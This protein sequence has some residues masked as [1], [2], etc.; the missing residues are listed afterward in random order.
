MVAAL[1]SAL[2][3]M[4]AQEAGTQ[5][6]GGKSTDWGLGTDLSSTS[7][8]AVSAVHV[9]AT[10]Y[11]FALAHFQLNH[12]HNKGEFDKRGFVLVDIPVI[13]EE[14]KVDAGTA[15]IVPIRAYKIAANTQISS[16]TSGF[17]FAEHIGKHSA[18]RLGLFSKYEYGWDGA[19]GKPLLPGSI[20]TFRDFLR[21]YTFA[22]SNPSLFMSSRGNIQI[23]WED[24]SGQEIE[25]EFFPN[26]IEYFIE[27]LG[28]EESV[29]A[30]TAGI[31][32]LAAK[33]T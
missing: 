12:L 4:P 32:R 30:T 3:Y 15:G 10:A 26:K 20:S 2:S 7:G 16:E 23:A 29:P 6:R 8:H 33:L 9:F 21:K 27:R 31:R 18:A 5:I 22:A 28:E 11:D 19:E 17:S 13:R 25:V 1:S 14:A 24:T